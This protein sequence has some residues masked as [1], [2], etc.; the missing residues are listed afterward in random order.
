MYEM[1]QD[2]IIESDRLL[3]YTVLPAEYELLEIDRAHPNLWIDRGFS[4]PN[5]HFLI[6]PDP[7]KHRLPRVRQHP[8]WAKYLL[9][10]AVLKYE[11]IVIGSAGFH[12]APDQNGMIEIGFT[13]DKPYQGRGFGQEILHAM[14]SWVVED[15]LVKILRYTVSP[16]N[17]ISQHIIKKFGFTHNGQQIDEKDGPED[18]YEL[19]TSKYKLKF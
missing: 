18:I 8:E 7:I 9:R 1:N 12:H 16:N 6:G 15:P 2:L 19:A 10:M 17:T 14:W 5:K 13:V 3:L 11:K 4:D